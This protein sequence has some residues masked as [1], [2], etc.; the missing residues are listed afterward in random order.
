[1]Q[2]AERGT[3]GEADWLTTRWSS[4][5]RPGD[6]DADPFRLCLLRICRARNQHA[7]TDQ[8]DDVAGAAQRSG[9]VDVPDRCRSWRTHCSRTSVVPLCSS[10]SRCCWRGCAT[11][12]LA[13]PAR[14]QRSTR[15]PRCSAD[16]AAGHGCPGRAPGADVLRERAES[17]SWLTEDSPR[18]STR[19]TR[20]HS[21]QWTVTQPNLSRCPGLDHGAISSACASETPQTRLASP[22]AVM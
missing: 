6:R 5:R 1:M 9:R 11:T 2:S 4:G 17:A 19:R 21:S 22:P 12:S 13:P 15:P 18:W 20:Q 10:R 3:P 16:P 7:P 14:P 8:G